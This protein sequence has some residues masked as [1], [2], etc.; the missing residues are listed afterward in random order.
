MSSYA[1]TADFDWHILWGT[2]K[3]E[4][5]LRRRRKR[6]SLLG[7]NCAV[8]FSRRTN[9][10]VENKCGPPTRKRGNAGLNICHILSAVYTLPQLSPSSTLFPK[11][12]TVHKEAD[13]DFKR[14]F[15]NSSSKGHFCPMWVKPV[16]IA[17]ISRICKSVLIHESLRETTFLGGRAILFG[18]IQRWEGR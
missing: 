11:V 1:L 18:R 3:N 2:V 14:L 13:S 12:Y 15:S 17:S 10:R 4:P 8:F 16:F 7:G 5:Q 6:F 9:T